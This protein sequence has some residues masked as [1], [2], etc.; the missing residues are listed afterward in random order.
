LKILLRETVEVRLALAE[1]ALVPCAMV[2][3]HRTGN[4]APR[5]EEVRI[6]LSYVANG[7]EI[8]APRESIC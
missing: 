7:L 5:M 2:R 3:L 8:E 6:D 1:G 4:V